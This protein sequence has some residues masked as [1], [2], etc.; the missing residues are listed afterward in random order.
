LSL[1]S[2]FFFIL[3]LFFNVCLLTALFLVE[4]LPAGALPHRPAAIHQF[5][6]WNSPAL[7]VGVR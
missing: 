6:S 7:V 4:L 3:L 1:F 2:D 5:K